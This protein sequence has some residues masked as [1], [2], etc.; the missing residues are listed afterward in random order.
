MAKRF[1]HLVLIGLCVAASGPAASAQTT[2]VSLIR[3]AEIENTIRTFAAPLLQ[4]AGIDAEAVRVHLVRDKRINAFV[5][6]G[7]NLFINTGLLLESQSANQVIG[8]IAHEVGH[9]AGG[10][11]A[12]THGARKDASAAAILAAIL[13]AAVTVAGSGEGGAAVAATGQELARRSFLRHSRVQEQTADQAALRFLEASGQSP[14]GLVEFLDVLADQEVLIGSSLPPYLR[15]HPLSRERIGLLR[16]RLEASPFNDKPA[17]AELEE[18]HRRMHAKLHGFLDR[19]DRTFARY[20]EGDMSLEARYARAIAYYRIPDLERALAALDGLIAERPDDP[21]FHE[22]RGQVLF[23]NGRLR[24]AVASYQRAV[25]LLPDE[26]QLR[27][28]LAR[29]LTESGAAE[30]IAPAITHLEEAVRR[31]PKDS[32][33][34]RLLSVAY[35]RDGQLGMADLASAEQAYLGRR[36]DDAIRFATWAQKRLK[37][38]SPGWLRAADILTATKRQ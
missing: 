12:R 1:I 4:A 7:M 20:S 33:A 34:W 21:F 13:G 6:E 17:A 8:V 19:P 22:L 2:R 9:I 23:E 31:D 11:L 29:A 36:R 18:R 32:S 35:G 16:Y 10:H 37:E 28:G 25:D 3:D 24:E 26:P 38:G 30:A 14:R 27:V 15:T 5:A